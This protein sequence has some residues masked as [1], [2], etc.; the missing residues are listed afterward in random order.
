MRTCSKQDSPTVKHFQDCLSMTSLPTQGWTSLLISSDARV[1]PKTRSQRM[2]Q[3]AEG[4][5]QA[6]SEVGGG[7]S[8]HGPN[9]AIQLEVTSQVPRFLAMGCKS[10]RSHSTVCPD[11]FLSFYLAKRVEKQG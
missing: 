6:L 4:T 3:A 9:R 8:N 7:H 1:L 5:P 2:Q 11:T 10:I